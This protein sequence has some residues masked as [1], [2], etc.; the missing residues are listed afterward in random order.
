MSYCQQKWRLKGGWRAAAAREQR[1]R[2]PA[3]AESVRVRSYLHSAPSM[4]HVVVVVYLFDAAAG[5]EAAVFLF[6]SGVS[7]AAGV[8][9]SFLLFLP[10]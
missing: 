3:A 2:R 7:A 8:A 1:A 10:A 9:V 4:V 6:L 5:D